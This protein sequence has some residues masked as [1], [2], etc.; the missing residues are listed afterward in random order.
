M[1][2]K[3]V[4]TDL[5]YFYNATEPYVL[6]LLF[7]NVDPTYRS[8]AKIAFQRYNSSK[9]GAE[10]IG[11]R[12]FEP[13]DGLHFLELGPFPAMASSLGYYDE[14]S[15]DMK[16]I[17]PWLNRDSYQLFIISEKNLETFKERKDISEYLLFIRQYIKGK[18]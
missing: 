3:E 2:A 9:H 14:V 8:E 6:V 17:I 1:P 13:K 12:L 5:V 16:N 4:K 7:E 11:H 18:F 15:T 10:D